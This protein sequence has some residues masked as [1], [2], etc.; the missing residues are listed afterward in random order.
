MQVVIKEVEK[1]KLHFKTF[2]SCREAEIFVTENLTYNNGST[3]IHEISYSEF[4]ECWIVAWKGNT[5]GRR[6]GKSE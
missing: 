4:W 6:G 5:I 3:K 2:R 1:L